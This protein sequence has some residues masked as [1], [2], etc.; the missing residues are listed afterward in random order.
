LGMK[1]HGAAVLVRC[2]FN[3]AVATAELYSVKW[4][5]RMI[6]L[7]VLLLCIDCTDYAAPNYTTRLICR[8]MVWLLQ[9]S[10]S[11]AMGM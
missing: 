8:L 11:S 1:V 2:L 4:N 6:I 7:V 10:V 5:E 3:D 9:D